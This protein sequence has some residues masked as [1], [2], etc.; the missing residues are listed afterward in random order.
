VALAVGIAVA[1]AAHAEDKLPLKGPI[2]FKAY[3]HNG[4]GYISPEEFDDTQARRAAE[5]A[6]AGLRI[7][8]D[9]PGFIEFDKDEDGRISRKELAGKQGLVA[10][11]EGKSG[12]SSQGKGKAGTGG[13]SRHSNSAGKTPGGNGKAQK[14]A[15]ANGNGKSGRGTGDDAGPGRR[16]LSFSELDA[17]GDGEVSPEEFNAAMKARAERLRQQGYPM[18]R[19]EE[20]PGF[21][22]M[23]ADGNG[24]ISRREFEEWQRDSRRRRYER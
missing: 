7:V 8:P 2:P 15:T 4:D 20:G 19:S 16:F 3:D 6:A 12:K 24:L 13:K 22:E 23:D 5:R 18:S 1:A 10:S 11:P 14:H 17:T 9:A 21:K